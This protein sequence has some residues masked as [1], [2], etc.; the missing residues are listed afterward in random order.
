MFSLFVSI[1]GIFLA[2]I[3]FTTSS[4]SFSGDVVGDVFAS[5]SF[6]GFVPLILFYIV[7]FVPS[8]A[9]QVRRF[10][11]RDMSGWWVLGFSIL[12]NVPILGLFIS[13]A[14]F[15]LLVLPG[16]YGDNRFGPDPKNPSLDI[17]QVFS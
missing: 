15:V 14:W 17:D 2:T 16:T 13:V 6:V 4:V 10:H 12:S 11:D 1:V 7:I 3:G 8:V 5:S 9:V